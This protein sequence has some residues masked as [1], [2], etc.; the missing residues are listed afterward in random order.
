VKQPPLIRPAVAADAQRIGALARAAYAKYVPRIGREPSPMVADFPSYIARDVVVVIEEDGELRGFM[1]AWPEE[2]AYL[3][4]NVAVDPAAQGR[5]LGRK[6][7]EHAVSEARRFGLLALRLYTNVAMTENLAMYRRIGFVE[8]HRA[9]ENG[10][11][12]V[13]M[14][15]DFSWPRLRAD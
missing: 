10:F 11:N 3:V 2:D 12:R 9:M 15:W 8:T 1:I 14:R 6:L 7:F 5:G 13:Y 4:D